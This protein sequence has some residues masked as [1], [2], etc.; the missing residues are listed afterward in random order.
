MFRKA[1]FTLGL[2]MLGVW[3]N[4]QAFTAG[5][6]VISQIGT[7]SAGLTSAATATFLL[8]YTPAGGFV[9]TIAL[10]TAVVGNNRRL[11]N[12]GTATSEGQLGRSIDGKFL[13]LCGYDADTGTTAIAATT[14][15]AVN[16][17]VGVVAAN[18]TIDT[19]TAF[20]MDFNTGNPRS[21]IST[22]GVNLWIGGTGSGTG[23][24][25]TGGIRYA[26]TG[27][28]ASTRLTDLPTN[29][30]VTNIFDGQ[31]YIS[32][33]SGA[34][35][36]VSMVGVG[37]PTTGG[38]TTTLIAGATS[39]GPSAYDFFFA[40][41]TTLYVADDRSV[42]TGGGIQKWT[43]DGSVWTLTYTLNMGPHGWLPVYVFHS[44][45]AK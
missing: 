6:L 20:N 38:Q 9:Q 21:A 35:Q 5:D 12:S 3:A 24:T 16:R 23:S 36:G 31:L 40:D 45:R 4:S 15:A 28:T 14:S 25:A 11:T 1:F 32:S 27:S 30:R 34:F 33:A 37:L 17:V 22:D 2:A 7:G 18:G 43:F 29:V 26:T 42:A 39:A 44:R 8:E 10:P 19:T 13:T 41:S